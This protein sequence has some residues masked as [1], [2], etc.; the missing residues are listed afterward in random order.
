VLLRC[1]IEEAVTEIQATIETVIAGLHRSETL[2]RRLL[3]PQELGLFLL[4]AC[5][6]FELPLLAPHL[7][8]KVLHVLPE[9][10]AT[11]RSIIAVRIVESVWIAEP[12][13]SRLGIQDTGCAKQ[14]YGCTAQ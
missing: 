11:A 1:D 7:I 4:L 6:F 10:E 9:P 3:L 12:V 5:L 14:N 2:L 13:V 8:V